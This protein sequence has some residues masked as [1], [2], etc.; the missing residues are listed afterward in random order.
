MRRDR[1]DLAGVTWRKSTL[2]ADQGECVETA[3]LP[4]RRVAVRHSRDPAGD[5]LLCSPAEWRA[6]AGGARRGEFD[7]P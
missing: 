4:D 5:V 2:S 1:P 3:L 7:L 6:F